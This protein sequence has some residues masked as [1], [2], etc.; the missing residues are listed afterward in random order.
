MTSTPHLES[1]RPEIRE[2]QAVP[3]INTVG[4]GSRTLEEFLALLGHHGIQCL[5]DIR[6]YPGSRR[7]P[8]FAREALSSALAAEGIRYV[9]EGRNLGGLRQGG[10]EPHTAIS[11]PGFRAYCGHMES[12]CFRQA[13][14]RVLTLARVTPTAVMCAERQY[15][16]CHRFFLADHLLLRGA[17]AGGASGFRDG[18][19][20]TSHQPVGSSGGG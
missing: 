11:E 13:T 15:W 12:D 2:A 8:H 5:V 9:W 7:H 17:R 14:E 6:S 18:G 20:G 10:G 1:N 4:H 16:N 3:V 19:T